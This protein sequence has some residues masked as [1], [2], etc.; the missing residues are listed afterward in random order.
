MS[1]S[2]DAPVD[3]SPTSA[4]GSTPAAGSRRRFAAFVRAEARRRPWASSANPDAQSRHR[5]RAD[6]RGL[7]PDSA[8][9][10]GSIRLRGQRAGGPVDT[11]TAGFAIRVGMI[12]QEPMTTL[13]P[14]HT[15]GRQVAD[16]TAAPL[17][18]EARKEVITLLIVGPMQAEARRCLPHQ[19]SGG[20]R[21]RVTIA[22]A[23]ACRP[24][25]LIADSRPT[26]LNVTIQTMLDLI[27]DLVAERRHVDDPDLAPISASSPMCGAVIVD[28]SR[29]HHR[30]QRELM[31]HVRAHGTSLY[32]GPVR[33]PRL[34]AR[35]GT[36]LKLCAGTVPELADLPSEY[37]SPTAAR[38]SKIVP[39][40]VAG[41]GGRHGHGVRCLRT[42]VSL[43]FAGGRSF[44]R[45][46]MSTSVTVCQTVPLDVG[47]GAAVY[48]ARARACSSQPGRCMRSMA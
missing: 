28:V 33:R 3:R 5:A 39:G 35:K 4:S 16:H 36:A 41:P 27:A 31:L 44:G 26:A 8:V 29:H 38:S 15:I 1:V 18:G 14:M 2:A 45:M 17:L 37:T 22:M 11:I 46:T 48:T 40:G 6:G 21:Q 32:A 24:D 9:I 42:D 7:L 12:F 43:H 30:K 19:F 13:N 20:Q 34:G 25:V 47:S 10:S 23:L